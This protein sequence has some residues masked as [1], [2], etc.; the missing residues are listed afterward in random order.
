M[1]GRKLRPEISPRPLIGVA[2]RSMDWKESFVGKSFRSVVNF[3]RENLSQNVETTL[4]NYFY[5]VVCCSL[6]RSVVELP[7][8]IYFVGYFLNKR[9]IFNDY[10]VKLSWAWT[11]ILLGSF[12]LVSS[13]VYSARCYRTIFRQLAR[14]AVATAIW[15]VCVRLF[16]WVERSGLLAPGCTMPGHKNEAECMKNGAVWHPFEISGHVFILTYI[17]LCTAEELTIFE[18][19]ERL[20]K[21]LKDSNLHFSID[22]NEMNGTASPSL[23]A[24][25]EDERAQ[26]GQLYRRWGWLV[27]VFYVLNVI[28]SV[29]WLIMITITSLYYHQFEHKIVAFI[30]AYAVWYATYHVWYPSRYPG[31]PGYDRIK[32]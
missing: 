1:S 22:E 14:V 2:K 20:G 19:W 17:A 30:I 13:F 5:I 3:C 8:D 12:L 29:F 32:L 16:V 18:R 7:K 31:T 15:F 28:F 4:R 9:N 24:L 23:S 6:I 10:F 11:S 25:S 21:Y 27:G 26:V